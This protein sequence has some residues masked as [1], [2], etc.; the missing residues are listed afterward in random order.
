M[1]TCAERQ[2]LVSEYEGAFDEY[3]QSLARSV[4]GR[5]DN[6]ERRK[7]LL[8]CKAAL[9]AHCVDRAMMQIWISVEDWRSNLRM[10]DASATSQ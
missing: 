4:D 6:S 7:V 8:K 1:D 3:I 9:Q 2:R 10:R 5:A